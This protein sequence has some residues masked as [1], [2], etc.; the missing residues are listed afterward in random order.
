MVP[1]YGRPSCDRGSLRE[2]SGLTSFLAISFNSY[3]APFPGNLTFLH[4]VLR[5]T[6][7]ASDMWA[8]GKLKDVKM[9][10]L[11]YFSTLLT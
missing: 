5:K 2:S 1:S 7:T 3:L 8:L 4:L 11:S 9:D 6:V 10:Y